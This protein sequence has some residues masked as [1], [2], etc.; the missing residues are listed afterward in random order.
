ML[1]HGCQ[2]GNSH[3]VIEFQKAA[4]PDLCSEEFGLKLSEE[5]V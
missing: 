1:S 4:D 5:R 3:K 2:E